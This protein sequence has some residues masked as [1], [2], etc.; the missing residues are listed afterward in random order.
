[1]L[2]I[3]ED[4]Q[5][6][7]PEGMEWRHPS[8]VLG[9]YTDFKLRLSPPTLGLL[10]CL[11][12]DLPKKGKSPLNGSGSHTHRF[13][14]ALSQEIASEKFGTLTHLEFAPGLECVP[15]LSNT[16]FPFHATNLV[17]ILED[18]TLLIVDPGANESGKTHLETVLHRLNPTSLLVFLTHHHH[19]HIQSLDSIERLYPNSTVIGH[20][21]TL[22]KIKTTLKQILVCQSDEDDIIRLGNNREIHVISLPGH[23]RGHLALWDPKSKT[24]ISGDHTVGFGSSVLDPDGGGN[25]IAYLESTRRLLELGEIQVILPCHGSPTLM[26]TSKLLQTYIDHRMEREKAIAEQWKQG[27]RS[28]DTLVKAVYTDTPEKLHLAAKRNVILH[29]EKLGTEGT[30]ELSNEVRQLIQQHQHDD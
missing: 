9:D 20:P 23:T 17:T 5:L 14:H 4:D 8:E 7:K 21:Y 25:M 19:D 15:I 13:W 29:L 6:T 10:R 3:V 26:N 28:V 18:G 16:L 27:N 22:N 1:M 12:V 2:A 30:I 11:A 24:L